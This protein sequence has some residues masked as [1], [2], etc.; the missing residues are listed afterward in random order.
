MESSTPAVPAVHLPSRRSVVGLLA[1]VLVA[2]ALVVAARFWPRPVPAPVIAASGTI[3][4]TES[5]ISPK[6]QGRLAELRVRDG[7]PVRKGQIVAVL[8]QVDPTL[9]LDQARANVLAAEAQVASAQAAYALQRDTYGTSLAQAGSGVRI[10]GSRL[11]QAGEDLGIERKAATLGVDSANAQVAAARSAA[12]HAQTDLARA[13][14]LVRTGDVAQ[15][16]LDDAVNAAAT[17]DAQLRAANDGLALARANGRNVNVR[18]LDVSASRSQVNQSVAA[19]Q[20]AQAEWELVN[21]RRAQ[22]A[23][24]QGALGQTRAALRLAEDRVR[25]TQLVAPYDGFVVSH[26]DEVGDLVQPG[27]AVMT[28]GDLVHPY[29]YVY[30]SETDLPRVKTGSRADVAIDGMPGR[31]YAGTVTEIGSSA[32]FTP[33]N[34]QTKDERIEYLVFQVKIQF[35]DKSRTLKPG[36]PADATIHV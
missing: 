14:A 34:V 19:L 9:D 27:T 4:A 21:E 30:V 20:S 8:E 28:I 16:V 11:G 7:D 32:E 2:A 13:R 26:N 6:V 3:E 10:A 18:E 23:A 33:E 17:A 29:L 36:L 35:T 24:A 12:A 31:T 15:Q 25:E 5:D 22:V 1:V